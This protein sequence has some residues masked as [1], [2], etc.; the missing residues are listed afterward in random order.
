[1][2]LGT[3]SRTIWIVSRYESGRIT[4]A[5]ARAEL[6]EYRDLLTLAKQDREAAKVSLAIQLLKT[7]SL[8]PT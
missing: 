7:S 2:T 1:M 3:A 6:E 8:D 5:Q 4:A